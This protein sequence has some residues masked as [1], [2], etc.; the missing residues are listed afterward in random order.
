MV[1]GEYVAD[2]A[3]FDSINGIIFLVEF[4]ECKFEMNSG[5]LEFFVEINP[6]KYG[7]FYIKCFFYKMFWEK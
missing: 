1:F 3:V 2:L 7:V 4:S 5:I 6:L